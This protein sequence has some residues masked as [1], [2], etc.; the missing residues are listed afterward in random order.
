LPSIQ[1]PLSS[2][3]LSVFPIAFGGTVFG[4]KAGPEQSHRLLDA[5]RAGGGNFLDTADAYLPRGDYAQGP[6]S[7][8][9]IGSWL[10]ESGARD[11][12][13]IATKV[14]KHPAFPGLSAA[15]IRRAADASLRRLQTDRIDLYFAHYDDQ[16]VPVEEAAS[17][18]SALVDAGKI[19]YIGLSNYSG[20]RVAEWLA[21]AT[22]NGLHPPIALQPHYNLVE[23]GGFETDLLP[24]AMAH[25]LATVPY[26]ALA[27]GF[28][29]GKYRSERDDAANHS[30]LAATYVNERGIRV[31]DV[32]A[33]IAQEHQTKI[34]TVALAWLAARPTVTAPISSTTNV[35]QMPALLAAATL[36]LTDNDNRRLDEVS[37]PL[38]SHG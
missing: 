12:M 6:D 18:F 13:V 16:E 38:V 7:E 14:G 34:S 23:R 37:D 27:T 32:L 10:R 33:T 36:R 24:V 20:D 15:N 26:W 21:I 3:G 28:L 11:D 4:M 35:G 8:S 19:R 1:R 22:E 2:T 9:I 31:L 17:A 25:S 30:P 5:Y 29:T